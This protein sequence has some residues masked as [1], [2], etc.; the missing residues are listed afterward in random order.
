MVYSK[1]SL[2]LSLFGTKK[3]MKQGLLRLIFLT[4]GYSAFSA[5][6]VT[7]NA[8]AVAE[9]K[10]W[11]EPF[12]GMEFVWV[13]KGCFKMGDSYSAGQEDE[14]PVHEVCL[15]GFWLGKYEVTQG[16]W[17]KIIAKNPSRN[18]KG[19]SYPVET[20]SWKKVQKY[21]KALAEKSNQQFNLP[22][23]AQWEY[24]CTSGGKKQKF[25]GFS[26]KS[27]MAKYANFCDKNCKYGWKDES[28]DD[29]YKKTAPVGG[30]QPNDIGIYDLSGNVWEWLRDAYHTK[31]YSS[32]AKN[33]PVQMPNK[34]KIA[35]VYRGGAWRGSEKEARCAD[36]RSFNQSYTYS[37]LGF[38]LIRED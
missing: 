7:S 20:V 16:Q 32:H 35:R 1:F 12:T 21:I 34:K 22:T 18:K 14:K 13:N 19:D 23:E 31:A 11:V 28:Q 5:I 27:K 26:D 4:L 15:D 33:N 17:G 6:F 29:G 25:S 36:R 30:Y 24:A 2:L 8:W 10:T 9:T 3:T 38:R 37:G